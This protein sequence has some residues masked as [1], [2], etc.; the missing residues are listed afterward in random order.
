MRK[1]L[2][3][4]PL[5]HST[6]RWWSHLSRREQSLVMG[7]LVL[8]S[9]ATIY[10]G[11][12]QPLKNSH[13]QSQRNAN[14]EKLLL[15]WVSQKAN[16]ITVL[17]SSSGQKS[18]STQPLNQLISSSA[19]R[20]KVELIR[21][22]PRDNMLQVWITPVPFN[23]LVQWISYLQETHA[24]EVEFLDINRIGPEGMVDVSRLQFKRGS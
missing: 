10:W 5:W 9:I 12:Y 6:Q 18:P 7:S 8:L 24:I 2:T 17:R 20:F 4:L 16:D 3:S 13:E 23:Q 22:Q 14:T 21:V 1:L 19:A 11:V 15:N